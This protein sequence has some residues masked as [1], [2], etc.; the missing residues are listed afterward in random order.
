MRLIHYTDQKPFVLKGIS[1]ENGDLPTKPYGGLWT[2]PGEQWKEWCEKEE[3]DN[4][5]AK[6]K[7]I[8]EAEFKELIT[9][10]TEA[11]LHKLQWSIDTWTKQYPMHFINFEKMKK[12]G[13][14]GIYLTDA[15]QWAT[16]MTNPYH[17]YGWDFESLLIL[18]EKCIRNY[19]EEE[20]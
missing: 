8:I 4:I 19:Y 7:V 1:I 16:R 17:L 15:G 6:N 20:N 9:I 2:C 18:N 5:E 10:D 13:V 3:F 11:D 14:D 12:K